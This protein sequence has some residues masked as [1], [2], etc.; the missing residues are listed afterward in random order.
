LDEENLKNYSLENQCL[1]LYSLR[2]ILINAEEELSEYK[3]AYTWSQLNRNIG[4]M[5]EIPLFL[6]TAVFTVSADG[7]AERLWTPLT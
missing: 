1:K 6:N 4:S 7:Q 5:Q 3:Y 2:T